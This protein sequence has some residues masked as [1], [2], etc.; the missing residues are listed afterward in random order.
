MTAENEIDKNILTK[1]RWKG[2]DFRI[3]S[4]LIVHK[5]K[6][7]SKAIKGF[8]DIVTGNWVD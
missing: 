8:A 5:D 4:Q 2:E 7:L 3:Y 1:L 6:K